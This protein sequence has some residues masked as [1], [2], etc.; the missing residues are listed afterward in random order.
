MPFSLCPPALCNTLLSP[1]RSFPFRDLHTVSAG[2]SSGLE[3]PG[4][5][6]DTLKRVMREKV[7]EVRGRGCVR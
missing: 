2:E 1:P 4:D 6:L 3:V 7:D 5:A